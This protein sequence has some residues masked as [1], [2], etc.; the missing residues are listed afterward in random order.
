ML[1][2]PTLYTLEKKS[3]LTNVRNACVIRKT[4]LYFFNIRK[5]GQIL[6]SEVCHFQYDHR[7]LVSR[8]MKNI[9]T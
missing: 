8:E 3:L 2:I 1:L 9:R 6:P 7:F 5:N 4:N